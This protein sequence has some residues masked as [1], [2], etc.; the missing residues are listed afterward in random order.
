MNFPTK[1]YLISNSPPS[2][3][4]PIFTIFHLSFNLPNHKIPN[5]NYPLTNS[6]YFY[7]KQLISHFKIQPLSHHKTPYISSKNHIKS[8]QLISSFTE[9]TFLTQIKKRHSN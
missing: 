1:I 6:H 5:K 7:Q 9:P 2:L 4:P 8:T 3:K